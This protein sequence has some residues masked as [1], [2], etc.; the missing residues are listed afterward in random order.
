[1]ILF[2]LVFRIIP[3]TL[4]CKEVEKLVFVLLNDDDDDDEIVKYINLKLY[5]FLLRSTDYW[6]NSR[7]GSTRNRHAS[8]ES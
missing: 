2:F 8:K 1:M 3:K 5:M 6:G 4:M 7:G